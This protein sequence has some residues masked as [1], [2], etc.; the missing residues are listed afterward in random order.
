VL[1]DREGR[2]LAVEAYRG[3]T[4][5][6]TTLPDQVTKRRTRF[7]GA[8]VVLVGAR[9]TLTQTQINSLKQYPG[10]G[11]MSALRF[12]AIRKLVD[13]HPVDP[14]RVVQ[15]SLAAITSVPFPGERLSAGYNPLVAQERHRKRTALLEATEHDLAAMSREVARRTKTPLTKVEMSKKVGLVLHHYRR[16]KPFEVHI[17]DGLL[18]YTRRLASIPRE[19]ELDGL[20]G[21]RTSEPSERLSADDTVRGYKNLAVG[22]RL[23]RTLKSINLLVR[24][25]YH[26]QTQRVRAHLLLCVLAY[27]VEWHMR[28]ALAPLRLDDE[29]WAANRTTRD[30][31]SPAP[32]SAAA[33]QKK[34]GRVTPEGCPIQSFDPLLAALGTR[35]RNRCRIT[36]DPHSAS[37]SQVTE[38]TPCQRQALQLLGIL[39]PVTRNQISMEHQ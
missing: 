15:Q 29:D 23:F 27:Y 18:R 9:G 4:A 25:L 20:Y 21:S 33:Q 28:Q 7:R 32:P 37:F 22:E 10:L 24:P 39:L 5:E 16:G 19:A 2:P 31:V 13:T 14:V 34:A 1:T 6:P 11:W 17:D 38:P 30:P 12:E 35:C 36:S 8:Q 26:H 3:N